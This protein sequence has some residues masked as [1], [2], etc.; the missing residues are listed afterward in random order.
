[1][2]SPHVPIQEQLPGTIETT[3]VAAQV[4]NLLHMH[5]RELG[6]REIDTDHGL[7]FKDV[8]PCS[9]DSELS[10]VLETKPA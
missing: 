4:M 1:M 7:I 6:E 8:D 2:D 9:S 10:D 5:V 3:V